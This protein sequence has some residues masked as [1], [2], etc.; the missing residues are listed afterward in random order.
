MQN[1]EWPKLLELFVA[2]SEEGEE[3]FYTPLSL[4]PVDGRGVQLYGSVDSTSCGIMLN[5]REVLDPANPEPP[6][7]WPPGI[8]AK[9]EFS[10]DKKSGRPRAN[11]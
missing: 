3:G 1:Q 8:F 2:T 10:M 9:S 7:C 6:A 5:G 4:P 11:R